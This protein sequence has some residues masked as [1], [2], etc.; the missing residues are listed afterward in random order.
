M[1]SAVAPASQ[2]LEVDESVG[3][4]AFGVNIYRADPGEQIP[5][6]YHRHPDHENCSSF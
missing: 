2:K 3:A 6:G 5:W 1:Q 4:T